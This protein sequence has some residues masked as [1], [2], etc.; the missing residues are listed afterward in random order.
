MPERPTC[1][2]GFFVEV[3]VEAHP[4]EAWLV[5][6]AACGWPGEWRSVAPVEVEGVI[7]DKPVKARI[8]RS[9]ALT[10]READ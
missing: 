3:E 9:V 10:T 8:V 1:L 7:N 4:R 5:A 6:E 2:V